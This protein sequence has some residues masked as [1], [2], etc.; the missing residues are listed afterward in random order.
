MAS[1]SDNSENLLR[2]R[3][4][5]TVNLC[6][7]RYAPCFLG[8]LDLREQ[9]VT[10]DVLRAL[11]CT[12]WRLCGGY[13]DAERA[14]LCV[15]PDYVDADDIVYPFTAVGFRYRAIRP[16]SHRDFLGTLLSV[17][18]RRDTIGDILCGEGFSVVFFREEVV[19]YICEHV[20]R[21][22]GEGV[23]LIPDY[24]GTVPVFKEFEQRHETVASPRLDAV[25]KALTRCSREKAAEAIR[26]GD[27]SVDHR[28][29][30]T[31]SYNLS[32]PC[33]LSIRGEGRF[34]VDQIGPETKKGRLLLL[35]R[36]CI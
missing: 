4:E 33:T 35:A 20:T 34:L 16:L 26:L 18:I 6:D 36:K 23:T 10:R 1:I 2:S 19:D 11:S 7:K 13:A 28:P 31:V 8:F 12:N 14:M 21:I 25:V 27:I 15:Y 30:D 24:D 17:G 29:V 9:A 5:D 3:I 32:A 22:G